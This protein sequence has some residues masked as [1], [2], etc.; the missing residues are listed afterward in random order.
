MA[1]RCEDCRFIGDFLDELPNFHTD[2]FSELEEHSGRF[3]EVWE[4]DTE[5][6]LLDTRSQRALV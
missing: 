3:A 4:G 6:P 2:I 5:L 1:S